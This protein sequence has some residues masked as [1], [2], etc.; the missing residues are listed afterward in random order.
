MHPAA[1]AMIIDSSGLTIEQVIAE[2]ERLVEK[3]T[4]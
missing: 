4:R 3:K 1:D 2:V